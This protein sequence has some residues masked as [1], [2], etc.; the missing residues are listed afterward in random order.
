MIQMTGH[1]GK[2]KGMIEKVLEVDQTLT[3]GQQHQG[4]IVSQKAEIFKDT[5]SDN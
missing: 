3:K 1:V 5:S 2:M 4:F